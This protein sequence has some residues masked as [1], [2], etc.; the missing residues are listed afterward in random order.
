MHSSKHILV[1]GGAGFIGSHMVL[2]LQEAGYIPVV[3]DNLSKGHREAVGRAELMVA[4]VADNAAL[5]ALFQKYPFAAVMHF[6]SFI[7]VGES[8]QK[9]LLYYQ[10][11]VASTLNLFAAMLK[12]QVKHF[13]FSS[14]AAVYGEPRYSPIDEKHPLNPINPYGRSKLML[15]QIIQDLARSHGLRFAI[16]RYFNAAGAD[17]KGRLRERHQPESHLIPLILQAATGEREQIT[18]YGDD[19]STPDGT[20]VRDYIH[21]TDLCQAHLLALKQLL[22]NGEDIICNLGTGEGY[23]VREVI[24][25]VQQVINRKIPV[26]HGARRAG[27]PAVLVADAALAMQQLQWQPQYSDLQ[28]IIRHA[29]HAFAIEKNK[30]LA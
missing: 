7:E 6:A 11:N 14:S 27:D 18:I 8:V 25:M 17:P 29:W 24:D 1:L 3:L 2:A 26:V 23:S 10:N 30:E 15:E 9:P 5:S 28:T 4:D 20:C 13:I 12:H 19:Y 21:V 22:N 16:L